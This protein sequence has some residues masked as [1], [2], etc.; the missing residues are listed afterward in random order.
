MTKPVLVAGATGGVGR[1]IVQKLLAKVT[2][3]RVLVRDYQAAQ[4]VF[5]DNV[6]YIVGEVR[7]PDTLTPAVTGVEA[8]I[9]AIGAAS[10][11]NPVNTPQSVDFEG[12]RN[13]VDAAKTAGVQQF[14]LVSWL[15]AT[16]SDHPLNRAYDNVLMWKLKGEDALRAS[17]LSYVIIRPGALVDEPG[18][19][20]MLRVNQGDAREFTGSISREDVAEVA[21]QALNRPSLRNVTFELIGTPG[22]QATNWDTLFAGLKHDKL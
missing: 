5:S 13:L 6:E 3:T 20:N 10:G 8:I 9:C 7:Q 15:G 11:E 14:V 4:S 22:Q 18:G 19:M 12:V 21:I 2:P 1:Q 16:H 17:G